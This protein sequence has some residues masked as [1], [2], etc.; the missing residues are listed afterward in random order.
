MSSVRHSA[1]SSNVANFGKI[2]HAPCVRGARESVRKVQPQLLIKRP[3]A[4]SKQAR[5]LET[6]LRG[7]RVSLS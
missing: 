1:G 6:G 3:A 5:F 2:Q 4:S 7:F